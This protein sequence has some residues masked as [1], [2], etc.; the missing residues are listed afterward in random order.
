MARLLRLGLEKVVSM[1]TVERLFLC[2]IDQAVAFFGQWGREFAEGFR[3]IEQSFKPGQNSKNGEV[4][5]RGPDILPRKQVVA[6]VQMAALF[7]EQLHD[8][9]T[10]RLS[11]SKWAKGVRGAGMRDFLRGYTRTLYELAHGNPQA[12]AWLAT[13]RRQAGSSGEGA[14]PRLRANDRRAE[15]TQGR[16]A[17]RA[18]VIV[19]RRKPAAGSQ[20][21]GEVELVD[22]LLGEIEN[23]PDRG[24]P[25]TRRDD[26]GGERL[27]RLSPTV[28][29]IRR[30]GLKRFAGERYHVMRARNDLGD[31]GLGDP[32]PIPRLVLDGEPPSS[33]GQSAGR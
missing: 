21:I 23:E 12:A 1:L 18:T 5:R 14:G 9:R 11:R 19:V 28:S 22:S 8:P 24:R 27:I 26:G 16:C 29:R 31:V 3:T 33:L 30:E 10:G 13:G 15:P 20:T 17:G 7:Q 4:F 2:G 32:R 25:P 6:T